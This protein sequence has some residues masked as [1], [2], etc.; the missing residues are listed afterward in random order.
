MNPLQRVTEYLRS[1]IAEL[2][3]VTWPTRDQ[4]I[5]YS[6]LVIGVSVLAG[7][8]FAGLDYGFTKLFD[9]TLT[10]RPQLTQPTTTPTDQPIA[11]GTVPIQA[12]PADTAQ[13]ATPA[14]SSSN[15]PQINFD[16]VQPIT[17]PADGA[18]P[19]GNT[20]N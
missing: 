6:A 5:R 8:F 10:F 17:T 16:Q 19:A 4:T 14:D 2:K 18:T 9:Y 15:N 7:A 12:T 20:G 11:S 13:P 3:K 1:S